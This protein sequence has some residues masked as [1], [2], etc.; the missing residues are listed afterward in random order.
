MALKNV[1]WLGHSSFII[2]SEVEDITIYIDPYKIN[3]DT[4]AN[5]IFL[6]HTHYDHFS[7]NDIVSIS[8]KD[9]RLFAPADAQPKLKEYIGNVTIVQP[10]D[11]YQVENLIIDTVP[12]YNQFS[13]FHPKSNN[14]V[15]YIIEL[16]GKKYFHSGDTDYIDELNNLKSKELFVAMLPVGGTYTMDAKDAAKLANVIKPRY[17]IPMHYGTV[18]GDIKDAEEFKKLFN[19]ETVILEKE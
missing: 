11:K 9:T 13:G 6:T 4:I 16:D 17:A 2:T 5:Y 14:W 8:N 3:S 12:A 18:I 7:F 15:G 19:G 10:N 1:R